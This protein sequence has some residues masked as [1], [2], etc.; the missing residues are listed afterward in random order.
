MAQKAERFDKN[1]F[2]IVKFVTLSLFYCYLLLISGIIVYVLIS[3]R[4]R[5]KVS[6]LDFVDNT[7]IELLREH[8]RIKDYSKS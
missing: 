6:S 1:Y 3:K 7:V 2:V 5:G 8:I 4:L